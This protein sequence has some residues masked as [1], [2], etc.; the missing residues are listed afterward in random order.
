MNDLLKVLDMSEDEQF[1][2]LCDKGIT[3]GSLARSQ[4]THKIVTR[5]IRIEFADLA[6]RFRDKVCNPKTYTRCCENYHEAL[7]VVYN[8]RIKD[9][10]CC[11]LYAWQAY[12]IRPIDM[13]IAAL[14]AK[15]DK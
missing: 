3:D 10:Q 14:I 2:W 5:W 6:F 8:H 9:K 1:K 12:Q 13:I 11:S 7:E 15:E 4:I